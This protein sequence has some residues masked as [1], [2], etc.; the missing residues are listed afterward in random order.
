MLVQ[1][2]SPNQSKAPSPSVYLRRIGV[3]VLV[4]HLA[5]DNL[6][7][8]KTC[9]LFGISEWCC[10]IVPVSIPMR[11]SVVLIAFAL[12]LLYTSVIIILCIFDGKRNT[13]PVQVVCCMC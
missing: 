4:K 1:G 11:Q 12:A 9:D 10:R 5:I 6:L 2:I 8:S 13:N 3:Y 7:M